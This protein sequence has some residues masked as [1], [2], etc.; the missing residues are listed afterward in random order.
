MARHDEMASEPLDRQAS[1]STVATRCTSL[2]PS[3]MVR[4]TDIQ[5][6]VDSLELDSPGPN[7]HELRDAFHPPTAIQKLSYSVHELEKNLP[8]ESRPAN[9]GIVVPGVYRSSFPQSEDYA[10]IEGLKLKTIV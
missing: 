3:P 7:G 2:E 9:F 5:Q 1:T 6:E 10:F 8:T 4:P